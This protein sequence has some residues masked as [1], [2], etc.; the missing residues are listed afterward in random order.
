[1][2]SLTILTSLWSLN[3][4]E[5][6]HLCPFYRLLMMIYLLKMVIVHTYGTNQMVIHQIS[7]SNPMKSPL[8]AQWKI[9][10]I[11]AS[12]SSMSYRRPAVIDGS[13]KSSP[14][15]R[16]PMNGLHDFLDGKM[17]MKNGDLTILNL[18]KSFTGPTILLWT[19]RCQGFDHSLILIIIQ[20]FNYIDIVAEDLT[21]IKYLEIVPDHFQ[22]PNTTLV[23]HGICSC[24]GAPWW[25]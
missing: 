2:F 20:C 7:Q 24:I 10:V 21:H 8:K 3:I 4:W 25:E 13:T 18:R 5:I 22:Y 15:Q 1:M 12:H 16:S 19:Q 6:A 9:T 23:W 17:A 11:P 14:S